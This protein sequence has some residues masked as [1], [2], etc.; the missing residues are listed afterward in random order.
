MQNNVMQ[1]NVLQINTMQ[2]NVLQI[3]AIQIDNT[4]QI[5]SITQIDNTNINTLQIRSP[6]P[7]H[8]DE[9]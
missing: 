3:N 5:K 7:S 2:N 1:N 8:F 6:S 4:T 9:F